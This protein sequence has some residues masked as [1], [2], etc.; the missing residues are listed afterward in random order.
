[1]GELGA[2]KKVAKEENKPAS[3][4]PLLT[5]GPFSK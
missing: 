2:L 4:L 5:A 3:Y 1:M